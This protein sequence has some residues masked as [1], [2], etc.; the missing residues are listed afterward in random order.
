M[1]NKKKKQIPVI[2]QGIS[3]RAGITIFT[4]VM[5]IMGVIIVC[6]HNPVSYTHLDVYKRQGQI[7]AIRSGTTE[8]TV[9]I[10]YANGETKTSKK[11]LTVNAAKV[12]DVYKRQLH[13]IV[14]VPAEG[15]GYQI[16][17]QGIQRIA[18]GIFG[19]FHG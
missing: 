4:L 9:T 18:V 5:L 12:E 11:T 3:K 16:Q 7:K 13:E 14:A 19:I 10:K 6:Y 1:K 2:G 17:A 15:G 8:I